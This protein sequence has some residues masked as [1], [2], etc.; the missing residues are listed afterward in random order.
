[1]QLEGNVFG[2]YTFLQRVGSGGMGEVYLA[3]DLRIERQVA[4]KVMQSEPAPYPNAPVT[5]EATR[6]FQRE[7]K[8]I[9]SLDHPNILP[10]LDFGEQMIHGTIYLYLVMPYRPEGSLVDWLRRQGGTLL[11]LQ[12]V[13]HLVVQ[14]A[15]ALQHAHR[16]QIIHLDVKA[17]NFLVRGREE[18]GHLPD[19]LLADFGIAHLSAATS[20]A[21]QSIRGTP[22]SMPPEQ[23]AGHPVAASDQYALAIMIY[24][25]LTGTVPFQG[26][27]QQ[28]MYQHL[29]ESPRPPSVHNA[30]ISA[31][32][33]TVLLRA[34]AKKP[35]ER[36]PSILAFTAAF[37]TACQDRQDG[38]SHEEYEI[39]ATILASSLLPATAWGTPMSQTLSVSPI[40]RDVSPLKRRNKA[41][42][43]IVVGLIV[44]VLGS[45]LP[46]AHMI[47]T[48]S[49]TT[50]ANTARSTQS[51]NSSSP[52][53]TI[54]PPSPIPTKTSI[55]SL[56]PTATVLPIPTATAL[57]LPTP[58]PTPIP[59]PNNTIPYGELLYSTSTPSQAC[60][61]EGGGWA[62]YNHPEIQCSAPGTL[63][64]NPHSASPDLVGTILTTIPSGTYPDN[65]V[66]EAQVQQPD[67]TSDFGI[68]FRNQSGYQEG[69]YTFLIHS[70]GSWGAYVYDN[71]TGTPS[72]IASGV[73]SI[74]ANALLRMTVVAIGPNFTF[75]V[76]GQNVGN[77]YDTTYSTGTAGVTVDA[78]GTV[79]VKS[80]S[81]SALP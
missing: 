54:L 63:I 66:V 44:I 1:M 70:D 28:M 55:A 53:T 43:A 32:I 14:V 26:N 22:S 73:T 12:D 7:M 5:Q 57:T 52:R 56:A 65:Y 51:S 13:V 17:S 50:S 61:T 80:F 37:Q 18:S 29:N 21:S 23:W 71:T 75:Y 46:F 3:E 58:V 77:A 49:G 15:E 2:H 79:Q 42:L 41:G 30:N 10:L 35:E 24:Q 16:H 6:L 40:S 25:L 39:P 27:M 72:Q 62:D 34:L 76:N 19:L 38:S 20:T 69:I 45:A 4:V 47:G 60:D 11:P 74:G 59:T 67:T 81:L 78:R 48:T 33:D 36:F 31:S 64:T 68:Y 9:V 8:A